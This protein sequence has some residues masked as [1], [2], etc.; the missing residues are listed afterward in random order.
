MIR[1]QRQAIITVCYHLPYPTIST[2]F[3]WPVHGGR[4]SSGSLIAGTVGDDSGDSISSKNDWYC[5]LTPMYWAWR[6]HPA[7]FYGVMHYRRFLNLL[8]PIGRSDFI[9]DRSLAIESLGL[10]EHTVL[11]TMARHD[12]VVPVKTNLQAA[13]MGQSVASQYESVH[14]ASDL[15]LCRDAIASISPEYIA[16][17]DEVMH[18]HEACFYNMFIMRA[19]LFNQYCTWLF[20]L[21]FSIE[22]AMNL[23][24]RDRYQQRAPA[25]LSERLLNVF[26]NHRS[27]C[28]SLSCFERQVVRVTEAGHFTALVD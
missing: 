2:P 5:E 13:G 17:Y 22:T 9:G 7:D 4:A 15:K 26:L 18:G 3:V 8:E 24:T 10:D 19:C 1:P 11:D 16:A 6:N 21:L 28:G 23:S 14:F 12:I 20:G 25:F 27:K